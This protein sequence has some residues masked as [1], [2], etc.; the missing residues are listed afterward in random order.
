MKKKV[1]VTYALKA[2]RLDVSISPA[3]VGYFLAW[4]VD[5][6]L[7]AT[8]TVKRREELVYAYVQHR[9][10]NLR[11]RG[12]TY[13]DFTDIFHRLDMLDKELVG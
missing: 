13:N 7:L 5:G 8:E 2:H 4:R 12:E 1:S 9:I 3:S 11:R 10:A 6:T